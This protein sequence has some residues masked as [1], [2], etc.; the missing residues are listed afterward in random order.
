MKLTNSLS[1]ELARFA[2]ETKYEELPKPIVHEAKRTLLDSIGCA[3]AAT[4]TDKGKMSTALARRFGGPPESSIIGTGDKVSCCSAAFANGELIMAMDY[5]ALIIPG[6]H[7]PPHVIPAL[8]AIAESG[9]ASGKDLILATVLA[10]E[11]AV[12]VASALPSFYHFEGSGAEEVRWAPR[13]GHAYCNFGA[14][15][16]AGKLLR[17]SQDEMLHAL[18]IAG[19]LCSVLIQQKFS[20]STHRPMTK[21]GVPG[22]Q[23]TG[24]VIAAL[25]AKMGYIGDTTVFDTEYGFWKFS[26]Y[27][28][29]IPDSVMEGIGKIWHFSKVH[30][31]PYPCCLMLHTVLDCF[32]T[33]IAQNNLMP[34]DIESVKAFCHPTVELPVFMSSELVDIVDAQF[35]AAYV[36]AVAAYRVKV[37]AEWQDWDTMKNQKIL[38]FMKKVSCRGH[39]EY[40]KRQLKDPASS[41]GMVEVL[42]KGK[43][44]KEERIY[45]RGTPGTDVQITDEELVEKFRHNASRILNRDK[46]ERAIKTILELET[47]ENISVLMKQVTL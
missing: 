44:L 5:D 12:R 45:S 30:Y 17:L 32:T 37:G 9:G 34:E 33:I 40:G 39:P 24:A 8:L 1:Q 42:S 25:L 13:H 23:S 10:H 4:I 38:E 41:L 20:F 26:G 6:G 36:F 27:A 19:C 3:L 18:G 35:C 11:I 2:V 7:V 46:I 28:E 22:W 29:W 31:K 47:T 15:A 21:Y 14:A 43:T 16:G